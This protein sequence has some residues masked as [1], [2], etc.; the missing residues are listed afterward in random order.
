MFTNGTM[1]MLDDNFLRDE[2]SFNLDGY[3]LMPS[4]KKI[5]YKECYFLICNA[6][7]KLF[8]LRPTRQQIE[9]YIAEGEY[10]HVDTLLKEN[11]VEC[12]IKDAEE[13]VYLFKLAQAKQLEYDKI[14]GR[15]A[16]L[17]GENMST[18][19]CPDAIDC[20]KQLGLFRRT[21]YCE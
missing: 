21:L 13:R 1:T 17:R 14:S 3:G 16:M 7:T 5:K 11:L 6:I 18:N 12:K 8:Y 4:D 2:T 10:T 20:I 15:A 9:T 19:L